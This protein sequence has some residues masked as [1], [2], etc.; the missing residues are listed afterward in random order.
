M[1]VVFRK[2]TKSIP[3]STNQLES[4]DFY[5]KLARKLVPIHSPS[6]YRKLF[7]KNEDVIAEVFYELVMADETFDQ[8]KGIPLTQWRSL[9]VKYGIQNIINGLRKEKNVSIEN[10]DFGYTQ[11]GSVAA[12]FGVAETI[13]DIENKEIFDKCQFSD[14]EKELLELRL[15]EQKTYREIGTEL[16]ISHEWARKNVKKMLEKYNELSI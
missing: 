9:R 11:H 3:F 16:G 10:K 2:V 13:E 15:V 8:S 5:D 6:R 4:F 1:S 7:S 14:K 12:L